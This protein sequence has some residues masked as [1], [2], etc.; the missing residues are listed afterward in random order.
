ML[1]MLS[2]LKFSVCKEISKDSSDLLTLYDLCTDLRPDLKKQ[3]STW[4]F[5][6]Y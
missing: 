1:K 5:S 2:L 3:V 6:A 4:L